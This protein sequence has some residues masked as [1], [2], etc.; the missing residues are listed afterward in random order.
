[1]DNSQATD[2]TKAQVLFLCTLTAKEYQ[3]AIR[4]EKK[5]GTVARRAEQAER[6]RKA[7]DVFTAMK[8]ASD[9]LRASPS[10]E[11]QTL[12]LSRAQITLLRILAAKEYHNAVRAEQK[13]RTILRMTEQ[14]ERVRKADD[15]YKTI[16]LISR[17]E[18]DILHLNPAS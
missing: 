1:M 8:R 10:G 18:A 2:L 3:N 6:V 13:A 12:E 5:A 9:G 15:L 16:K 17:N 14:A 4:A 7:D 11:V